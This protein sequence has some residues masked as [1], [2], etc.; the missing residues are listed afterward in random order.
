MTCRFQTPG[1]GDMAPWAAAAEHPLSSEYMHNVVSKSSFCVKEKQ[2][3]ENSGE[4]TNKSSQYFKIHYILLHSSNTF[5]Y[6]TKMRMQ[7]L[8]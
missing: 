7:P 5:G 6:A 3:N 4:R 2:L 1:Y 8:F